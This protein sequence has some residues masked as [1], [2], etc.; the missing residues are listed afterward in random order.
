MCTH[1]RVTVRSSAGENTKTE[2]IKLNETHIEKGE[3]HPGLHSQF[4]C[5]SGNALV[6]PDYGGKCQIDAKLVSHQMS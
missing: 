3:A 5:K 4:N 2:I 1:V 6:W